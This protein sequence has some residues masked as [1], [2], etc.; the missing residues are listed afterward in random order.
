[1]D[2]FMHL[3]HSCSLSHQQPQRANSA[4]QRPPSLHHPEPKHSRWRTS[5]ETAEIYQTAMRRKAR[6]NPSE[7]SHEKKL[8]SE[9][10]KGQKW[11][12][13][14]QSSVTEVRIMIW[15]TIRVNKTLWQNIK[16]VAVSPVWRL[17]VTHDEHCDLPIKASEDW[18]SASNEIKR[19]L[20]F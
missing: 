3:S 20:R 7:N 16:A 14:L 15:K 18:T 13:F 1:M 12:K 11:W 6:E 9:I 4:R 8:K 17:G 5:Y 10:E 2:C 19:H